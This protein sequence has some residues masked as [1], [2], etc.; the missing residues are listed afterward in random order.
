M[1]TINNFYLYVYLDPRKPGTYQYNNLS[2]NFE[3]IYIGKG[4]GNRDMYHY[5]YYCDNEILQRKLKKIVAFI[6]DI[7]VKLL[8]WAGQIFRGLSVN[9]R[10]NRQIVQKKLLKGFTLPRHNH[11]GELKQQCRTRIDGR[12]G[13]RLIYSSGIVK[14]PFLINVSSR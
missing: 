12:T 3:P 4:K 14:L 1:N 2:F 9:Q 8:Q 6:K 10:Q 11:G 13:R 7:T 5:K